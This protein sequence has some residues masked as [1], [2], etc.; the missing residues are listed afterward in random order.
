MAYDPETRRSP[1]NTAT[2]SR[3]TLKS[4]SL[5][6]PVPR[7]GLPDLGALTSL[8]TEIARNARAVSPLGPGIEADHD[9]PSEVVY[10]KPHARLERVAESA[11]Q[12]GNPVLLVTPP[13]V[14]ADCWDLRP[15]QSL[16]AHLA[17]AEDPETAGRPTYTIDY[18]RIGFADRGMG[19]ETWLTSLLP[20]AV[21]RISAE[22]DGRD[23]HLV[24]WS[25]GGTLSILLAAH[26]KDLP[27]AS[28]SAVGTPTDYRVNPLYAPLFALDATIGL[29][30]VTT[31]VALAG[32]TT[33]PFTQ[34]C[35]RALAPVRELTKPW[36]LTANLHDAEV[37]ARIAAVDR[38]ID[39]MPGYPARFIIQA[40]S[41]IV[42]KSEMV[43]GTVRFKD[44]TVEVRGLD[45]PTLL[46][47]STD[48]LLANADSVE[49]GVTAFP[50]AEVTFRRV[51]GLSHLGLVASPKAPRLT[52]P[53]VVEHL[54]MYDDVVEPSPALA[55][56]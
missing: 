40:V 22:H 49:A 32:R 44:L 26:R 48:D 28:V 4:R 12:T 42:C 6:V 2:R 36:T 31:P 11:G 53:F 29:E 34:F 35:Y 18:G 27:I 55:G 39:S 45:V 56:S 5:A 33:G 47:G 19:F 51:E 37:L 46:I 50:D 54:N 7:V 41:R 30:W 9:T 24:G 23:V 16:S 10:D 13:G 21:S 14:T 38:F 1:V 52:W 43:Q 17:G 25:H 20:D 3:T 8:L 15:G